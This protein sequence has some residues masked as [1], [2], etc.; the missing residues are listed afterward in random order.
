LDD[1]TPTIR[2]KHASALNNAMRAHKVIGL[3]IEKVRRV[4]FSNDGAHST[5]LD[6]NNSISK[7]VA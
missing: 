1:G 5:A 2:E 7:I 4:E 6:F 3:L